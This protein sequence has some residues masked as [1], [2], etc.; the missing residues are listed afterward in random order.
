MST[1]HFDCKSCDGTT[2]IVGKAVSTLSEIFVNS[3][4]SMPFASGRRIGEVS[5]GLMHALVTDVVGV[6]VM[7][8]GI[9]VLNDADSG[10]AQTDVANDGC[11]IFERTCCVDMGVDGMVDRIGGCCTW[12]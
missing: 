8:A 2:G 4:I 7:S 10:D 5:F 3:G 11:G 9:D 12:N 1:K 6:D